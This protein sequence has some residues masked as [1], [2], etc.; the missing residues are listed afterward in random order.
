MSSIQNKIYT[1]EEILKDLDNHIKNKL[2]FSTIRFGDAVYGML[3]SY[4]CPDVIDKD[5]WKMPRGKKIADSIM[6]QLTIPSDI[7][8]NMIKRVVI[9][10]NNANYC[11]SYVAYSLL[12]SAKGV[13]IIGKNW[14]AIH[15]GSGITNDKYCNCFLHYFSIVEGE[16]N[17]FDIMKNRKIFCISNQVQITDR[18]KT[19]SQAHT[20][21]SYKIPRRGRKGEH[22]RK[23]YKKIM[24]IIRKNSKMYDLFLIGAGFLG[25]I[26]CDEVKRCG[27][28][29]FDSGRLFD[30][31]GGLRTIDSRPKRFV[32]M[33]TT[34]ML[35]ERIKKHPSGVW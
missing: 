32:K 12:N 14:K 8:M 27:G 3:A 19:K 24:G 18:L 5:K 25:K 35:A 34:K 4:L 31:W 13:G 2:P 9:A 6:G 23:H 10:A 28:R 26:Y 30:F 22:Y 7:R 33:N 21:D 11:D 20:I 29:S 15:E 16:L 1:T 17:L